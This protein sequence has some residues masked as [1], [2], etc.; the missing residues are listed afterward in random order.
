MYIIE[1]LLHI[2]KNTRLLLH[3]DKNTRVLF[4]GNCPSMLNLSYGL[5]QIKEYE[6]VIKAILLL[7]PSNP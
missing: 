6:F 7:R 1:L 3:T 5:D 2:H 4:K